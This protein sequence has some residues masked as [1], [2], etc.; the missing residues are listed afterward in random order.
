[1]RRRRVQTFRDRLAVFFWHDRRL[2]T[3][4]ALEDYPAAAIN[5]ALIAARR[6]AKITPWLSLT[7][8][9]Q[10]SLEPLGKR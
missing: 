4:I 2:M 6:D 5:D 8:L 7:P 9:L 3:C 10:K 1:L